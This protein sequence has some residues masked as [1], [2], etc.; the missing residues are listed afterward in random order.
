[1]KLNQIYNFLTVIMTA[2]YV[3]KTFQQIHT[4]LKSKSEKK[5]ILLNNLNKML[6]KVTTHIEILIIY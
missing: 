4:M 2:F 5:V 1:M 3:K 6:I